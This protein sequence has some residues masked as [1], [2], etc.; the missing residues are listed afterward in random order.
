MGWSS[1]DLEPIF[2]QTV[3]RDLYDHG[4]K[5]PDNKISASQTSSAQTSGIETPSTQ[6]LSTSSLPTTTP[7]PVT[8][9]NLS[10]KIIAVIGTIV[11]LVVIAIRKDP[12]ES[13]KTAETS[14]NQWA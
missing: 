7:N 13:D 4:I 2:G 14:D 11:L 12:V 1:K 5:T 9:N 3:P 10:T 6:T 8:G